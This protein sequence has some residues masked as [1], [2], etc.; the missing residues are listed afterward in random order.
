MW[1]SIFSNSSVTVSEDG[2]VDAPSPLAISGD[3]AGEKSL[4]AR[5]VALANLRVIE[6]TGGEAAAFLQAQLCN[7]VTLATNNTSQLNGYCSPKG[8]LL[9]TFYVVPKS[10]AIWLI[11]PAD[12]VAGLI[13]RLRM[14]VMRADVQIELRDEFLITGLPSQT[15]GS[16]L[17]LPQWGQWPQSPTGIDQTSDAL[18]VAVDAT[19]AMYIAL[20][21]KTK[22]LWQA[23]TNMP[24]SA[25]WQAVGNHQH[26]RYADIQRGVPIITEAT[27]DAFVPQMVNLEQAGGL[28]FK[29]G[30][31]PGQEI[32]A[33]M[34]Y[35]GKLK[36]HMQRF[37]LPLLS[38]V[39]VAGAAL[40]AGDDGDAGTLVEVVA[41]TTT[42]ECLADEAASV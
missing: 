7:D 27:R 6:L 38:P 1:Q 41:T 31:Y 19:R 2:L 14:F 22:E 9:A 37:S 25:S 17:W 3:E 28:S 26:W 29:K 13:N 8:R 32:V 39:P 30:C 33:R 21:D 23:I 12:I 10:N 35:L 36:R 24:T 15:V 18:L 4:S 20:A 34:Q 16:D 5:L 42:I 11:V 40:Q